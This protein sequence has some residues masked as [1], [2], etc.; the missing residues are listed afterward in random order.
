M[1]AQGILIVQVP[2]EANAEHLINTR[3]QDAN[4]DGWTITQMMDHNGFLVLLMERAASVVSE[5][6]TWE[7]ATPEARQ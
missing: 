5:I 2:S 7:E 3:I 1:S 6:V 4:A